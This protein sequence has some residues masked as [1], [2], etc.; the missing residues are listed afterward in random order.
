MIYDA[1]VVGLGPAGSTAAYRLA[2]EGLNVLAFDKEKFP[3]YKPCGGCIS[4]KVEDV[5]G[6]DISGV[7]EDT[8]RGAVFTY[9]SGRTMEI[10]SDR[11]VGYNV[12]R[13]RFDNLLVEKAREAGAETIEGCRVTG[14]EE[15][16][17]SVSVVTSHNET[18]KAKFLVGAD[19]ASGFVGRDYFGLDKREAAVSITAEVP[20]NGNLAHDVTGKLF[21]DFGLVPFGYGWIFPKKEC[22]SV[23]MAGDIEKVRGKVKGYFSSFVKTHGLL[24]DMEVSERTGWT[25]PIFYNPEFNAVKGRVLVAGDTGHLVDPFLGEGIYYAIHTAGAA[26]DAIASCIR[27]GSA[28]LS[29][30]QKWLEREI[31]PEFRA[32]E[33]ISSLVYKYPRL[34]YALLEREPGIMLRYYDVIRGV[35]SGKS[36]YEW[37]FARIRSKPWKVLRGWVQSR[38]ISG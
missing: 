38:F 20:S 6:F 11:P 36:F 34:W 3:R 2:S 8:V 16:G 14:L 13:D 24:K 9:K 28:D 26:A 19:G 33:K 7:I 10:L 4:T 35:E 22:L 23:G 37:V 31:Y 18:F 27:D 25:V 15:T 29:P 32:A 12:M 21:I 30:Y 5:L 1:I 17:D